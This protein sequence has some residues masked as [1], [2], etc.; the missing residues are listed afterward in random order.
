MHNPPSS[1]RL[2]AAARK[3]LQSALRAK[4]EAYRREEF[5]R[6][7]HR[8]SRSVIAA[9]TPQAAA[10]VLKELER[11]LRAERARAGHW[12]YDLTR[13]IALLVAHRAEQARA[14]RLARSAHRSARDRV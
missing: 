7:F 8:L 11:A 3:S 1:D 10:V 2:R 12:T 9:E 6:S 4:A 13:H 5:L 14:L